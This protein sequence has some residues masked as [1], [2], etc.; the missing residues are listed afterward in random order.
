LP[1]RRSSKS[2]PEAVAVERGTGGNLAVAITTHPREFVAIVM[3][4]AATA[5]IFVNA[6]YLQRGPHPAPIFATRPL[7]HSVMLP[8]ARVTVP[9]SSGAVTEHRGQLVADIQQAL[10]QKGFYDGA[11]DGLWGA[12]TDSAVRD[13]LQAAGSD[14]SAEASES[15]LSTIKASSVRAG[16]TIAPAAGDPIARLL[17]PFSAPPV[18]SKR[19]LAVQRGLTDFGYG[20]I[21]PTGVIDA[22]TR[23]A[24]D[25]FEREHG[26]PVTG[27]M[28]DGL[29]RELGAMTGRPME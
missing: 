24:I 19:V 5:A 14:T 25:K 23:G 6:L 12:K 10:T 7:M 26:L 16:Q 17:A 11:I 3:A 4:M 21:K 2:Q 27:Q 15:L 13:F 29:V 28:S 1:R 9:A 22:E 8:P 18:P 20:Q